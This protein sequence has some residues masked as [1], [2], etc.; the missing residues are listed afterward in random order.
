MPRHETA[1]M[2]ERT[3]AAGDDISRIITRKLF[4]SDRSRQISEDADYPL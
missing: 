2:N 1:Y 3:V 4:L